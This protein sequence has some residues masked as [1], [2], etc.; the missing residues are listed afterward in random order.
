M[1]K[2]LV[3]YMI[4]LLIVVICSS[5]HTFGQTKTESDSTKVMITLGQLRQT[6]EIF[7]RYD[8][9]KERINYLDSELDIK[10][11]LLKLSDSLSRKYLGVINT[12]D[13]TLS[14]YQK[15]SYLSQSEIQRLNKEIKNRN[16][17]VIYYTIGGISVGIGIGVILCALL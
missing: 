7:I 12:Q 10:T 11:S 5:N 2:S 6:N 9:A 14:E 4:G 3:K 13:K 17:K 8:L 15:L 1:K 16:A